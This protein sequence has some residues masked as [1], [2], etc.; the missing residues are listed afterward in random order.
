MNRFSNKQGAFDSNG[1]ALHP[2]PA[3]T[4]CGG[5]EFYVASAILSG[6]PELL[7]TGDQ[8]RHFYRFYVNRHWAA[9]S[10]NFGPIL[11][12]P[13]P[14]VTYLPE[15]KDNDAFH[16]IPTPQFEALRRNQAFAKE[17]QLGALMSKLVDVFVSP[18]PEDDIDSFRLKR[19]GRKTPF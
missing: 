12:R 13:C 19:V 6:G 16:H 3:L 14:T 15:E 11:F 10:R 2:V 5:G 17:R 8:V 1:V 7:V 4:L 18:P 9:H